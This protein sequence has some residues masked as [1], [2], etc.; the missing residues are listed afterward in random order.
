M[1]WA[2]VFMTFGDKAKHVSSPPIPIHSWSD[3]TDAPALD[4]HVVWHTWSVGG[5]ILCMPPESGAPDSTR[6]II[7]PPGTILNL[8][9]SVSD[10]AHDQKGV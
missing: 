2:S 4:P 5:M 8:P 6:C 7:L 10:P 1:V 3:G 9:E